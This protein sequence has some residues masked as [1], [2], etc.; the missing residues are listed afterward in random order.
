MS[1]RV[2]SASQ[3]KKAAPKQVAPVNP[4][5]HLQH[6]E[7]AEEF[8]KA[9]RDLPR[10]GPS[11]IPVS[12][13][14]YFMLCHAI[15]LALKAFLLARGR[16]VPELRSRPFGHDISALMT[17]AIGLGLSIGPLAR[18]EIDRLSKAHEEF[19]HRYPRQAGDPVF[20]I[21]DFEHYFVELLT[22]VTLAIR[23]GNRLWVNY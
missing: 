19:W 20:V 9:F 11:G 23:G 4:L 1:K 3:T 10:E 13:P 7:L 17:E 14:R 5:V 12:W 18:S 16:T 8:L 15:E 6:L 2:K 22:A 21:D